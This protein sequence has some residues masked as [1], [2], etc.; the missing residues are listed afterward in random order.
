ML[1]VS[2]AQ[3]QTP[4]LGQLVPPCSARSYLLG[5][6]LDAAVLAGHVLAV[7]VVSRA[8]GEAEVGVALADGQVARALLG[9][10][11][12]LTATAGK[13]ILTCAGRQG[14]SGRDAG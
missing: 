11:L 10:A 13:A 4:W 8:A 7:P 2:Y 14:P 6:P 3:Q 5:A 12:G 1:G 9:I